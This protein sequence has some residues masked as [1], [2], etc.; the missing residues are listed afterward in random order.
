MMKKYHHCALKVFNTIYGLDTELSI[1]LYLR[2]PYRE[3]IT[4]I[5]YIRDILKNLKYRYKN[6]NSQRVYRAF[7]SYEKSIIREYGPSR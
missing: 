4:E 6:I 2:V 3:R 5:D 1:S 7:D